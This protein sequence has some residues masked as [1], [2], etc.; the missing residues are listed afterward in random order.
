MS[1]TYINEIHNKQ[2]YKETKIKD[3]VREEGLLRR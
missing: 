3:S 2:H 1:K